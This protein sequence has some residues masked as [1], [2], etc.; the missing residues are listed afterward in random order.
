M[1]SH[2]SG[3]PRL[4]VVGNGMAGMRTVEELLSRAPDRFDIT[5]I[6]AEPHPNYSRILL[7][8]VLAGE[9]AFADIVLNSPSWYEEHEI[10]LISG[11]PATAIDR[12][13]K[14]VV[15]ADGGAIPYDKMLLATGS[16]PLAPPIPG[17]DLKG[18]RAFRDIADVEAMIDAAHNHCLSLIHI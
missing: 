18:V 4:V 6:G 11:N 2:C 15:L 13:A 16:K 17:L 5:V 14:R 3:R 8:S 10:Q 1:N 12:A 7:S 9:R